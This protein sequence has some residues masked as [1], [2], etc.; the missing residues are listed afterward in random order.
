[1]ND[2]FQRWTGD[3]HDVIVLHSRAGIAQ[4]IWIENDD[5]AILIDAGDGAL[6]DIRANRLN[7][8]NLGGIFF[9]HGH[10]DH[11][12]GLHSILGFL[13]MI[14]RKDDLPVI[15]PRGCAEVKAVIESFIEI[16]GETIPFTVIS[17][18][19]NPGE[20][21][22]IGG[23]SIE[24]FPV[25]HCGS[26]EGASVLAPIP[27]MGYRV[28]SGGETVVIS[29]DTGDCETLREMAAGA[30][31]AILEATYEKSSDVSEEELQNVHLSEESA[32]EI[33]ALAR[34]YILVHK[35]RR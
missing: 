2:G 1:M 28:S 19:A 22:E 35:G 32:A 31:L 25:V 16:Y 7:R 21:F 5:R 8:D 18:E 9:T 26:I 33:G 4:H 17:R 30:D 27:A 13:R 3:K 14:G 6:R 15:R 29:G 24:A 10:F 34:E 20:K 23:M 11:M 12:G